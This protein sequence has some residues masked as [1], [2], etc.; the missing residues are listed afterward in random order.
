MVGRGIDPG[1][2]VRAAM[3]EAIRDATEKGAP[4]LIQTM[5]IRHQFRDVR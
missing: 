1:H 3:C 4:V 2:A 5:L